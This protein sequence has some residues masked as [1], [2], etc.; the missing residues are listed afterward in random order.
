M[1]ASRFFED[2]GKPVVFSNDGEPIVSGWWWLHSVAMLVA[3]GN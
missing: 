1:L 3:T 2:V